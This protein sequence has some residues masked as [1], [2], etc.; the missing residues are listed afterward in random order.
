MFISDIEKKVLKTFSDIT[1]CTY[2]I[3]SV[4]FVMKMGL[5]SLKTLMAHFSFMV[6]QNLGLIAYDI[7]LFTP[8]SAILLHH[9]IIL[10][11]D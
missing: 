4:I 6:A 3:F 2:I 7:G 5:K 1:I 11:K 9:T 10:V 8:R